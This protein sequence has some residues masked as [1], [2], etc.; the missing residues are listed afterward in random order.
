MIALSLTAQGCQAA[1]HKD[2]KKPNIIF[3][4]ADDMGWVD[5][6]VYG[7]DFYETPALRRLASEG[8][9]FTQAY[10]QPLCSPTRAAVLTG[11]YPCARL[12]MHSAITGQG[13]ANP[14]VPESG[15][16][17]SK[18]VYPE[19]RDRLPLEESTIAQALKKQ[20]YQTWH[21][22]KW[23]LSPGIPGNWE[24]YYPVNRGFD[25]QIG[26]GG[27]GPGRSYFAPYTVPEFVEGPDGE[28]IADRLAEEASKLM[29]ERYQDGPF[30][31]YY[32]EFNVHSPF[33]AKKELI[34]Y[35]AK[36]AE[37]MGPGIHRNPI[38]AAMIQ[39]LDDALGRLLD[40]IDELGIA[41]NT[42]FVFVSDNGGVSWINLNEN[43]TM[44]FD[45]SHQFIGTAPTSNLPLR[46]HKHT[47]YE[48]GVRVPMVVRW[49][50]NIEAGSI[51]NEIVHVIDFYPTFLE[52]AGTQPDE[53]KL[54]DGQSL[55][56]VFLGGQMPER[57]IFMH[58][59]RAGFGMEGGSFVRKGDYKLIRIYGDGP[60]RS[61]LFELYNL[62][63]D[64][65]EVNNL[66]GRM[67]EK[68]AE[69]KEILDQ[70]L[71]DTG[72]LM[73]VKNPNYRQ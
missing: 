31:M 24:A 28:Y 38:Y 47:Y 21:L 60:D 30:F 13:V 26:V 22:G 64:L 71:D 62:V 57:P 58:F 69:L 73:P 51:S 23:H 46:G 1:S 10:A 17:N 54:L 18:M 12:G 59:P 32:G 35:Y 34:D 72:A 41:D 3:F 68:L 40:E 52:V 37:S 29:R 6:D 16:P 25:V 53:G 15:A 45:G 33:Y 27:P 9:L 39:G 36:K 2:T 56:P 61:D 70:W 19:L 20:G 42:I 11:K 55:I 5:S 49:P 48:G 7:S 8:M 4:L 44:S 43:N 14:V 66:A 65:G 67:P 50:G 63:N